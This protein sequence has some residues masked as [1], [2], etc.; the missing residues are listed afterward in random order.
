MV[1]L[2]RM[3][4]STQALQL[5]F[6]QH[7]V[8]SVCF[9]SV[10]LVGGMYKVKLLHHVLSSFYWNYRKSS[11]LDLIRETRLDNTFKVVLLKNFI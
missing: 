3:R 11:L 2:V 4:K 8:L 6:P 9:A 1:D 10:F 5:Q 7:D